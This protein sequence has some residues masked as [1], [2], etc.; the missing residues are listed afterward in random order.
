MDIL[1]STDGVPRWTTQTVGMGVEILDRMERAVAKVRERLLRAA[2]ALN[3]MGV[4]YAVVGGNES[5]EY[6]RQSRTMVET[7]GA[8]GI[9]TRFATVA[10][11]N[12][13]TAIAPLA[14]PT[15]P[16]TLRLRELAAR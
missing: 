5:A 9:A 14:D 12:H 7:W 11:A 15:S 1:R 4:A 2:A 10:D 8:A 13:F 3:R 16:M 6:F